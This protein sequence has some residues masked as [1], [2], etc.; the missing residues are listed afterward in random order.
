MDLSL[1]DGQE[2]LTRGAWEEARACF[3]VAL[4]CEESPEV[5]EG[6]GVSTWWL[7]DAAAT[8]DARERAYRLYRERGDRL[9]AARLAISLAMDH[10]TFRSEFAIGNGWFRRAHRLLEGL[11]PAP[12]HGWLAVWEGHIALLYAGDTAAARR[13]GAAAAE[14]GRALGSIDLEIFGLA[15]EGLI[16]VNEGELAEGMHRLDEATVAVMAGEFT[17][18]IAMGV[19]CCYLIYACEWVR[20]YDRAAQWC[21][22]LKQFCKR[23]DFRSLFAYCRTHYSA[24]LMWRGD[25]AEA[26][27]ELL[28]ATGE[29]EAT[30]PGR[31]MEAIV[32]LAELRRRQGRLD[33]AT[34]LFEQVEF[35]PSAQLG[36]AAL[37]FD[38][39]DA[40]TA[41][42]LVER[43]LRRLSSKDRMNR[44]AGL[45][46]LVRIRLA[47]GE[48]DR[49]GTALAELRTVTAAVGTEVLRAS[50]SL[51]E[52]LVAAAADNHDAARRRFEDAVDLFGRSGTPFEA[53]Q[54]RLE[55]A[56]S[57]CALDR[58]TAAEQEARSA[59]NSL[60]SI[61]ATREADSA[62]DLLRELE[63][64]NRGRNGE[65]TNPAGLTQRELEI[66]G[67]VA[68]G[69][70]NQE[71]ASGLVLSEHTVHRHMANILGKLGL[72][73][74][75]AA[76]A[77][78]AR[79]GLL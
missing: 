29:L 47:L 30:R 3:E 24:V 73:S 14:L 57:L 5:L 64:P 28:A 50:T 20:D 49:A 12:E 33:E 66:L 55:L 8:F 43:F 77:Y 37:V 21:E 60:R 17:D 25:W 27:A 51:T 79:Q 63:V 48:P 9:A 41:A 54:A 59:L 1:Q 18:M 22:R 52:G 45:E 40:V 53:A 15:L 34:E 16:L 62:A 13:L 75:A 69:L 38:K 23:W 65:A 61:G 10:Y 2:A 78:A 35:Y 67:L 42:D 4:E 39:G 7:E 76:A 44:A 70:S 58:W 46:L 11:D 19:T 68:Q 6:L 71:V 31:V 36:R 32:R 74:R 56:R 72:P 26:E